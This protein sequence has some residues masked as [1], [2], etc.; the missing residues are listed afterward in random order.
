MVTLAII[1]TVQEPT[2]WCSAMV[3]V[4]KS[5]ESCRICVDSRELNKQVER[6]RHPLP[7]TDHALGQLG[8]VKF[9]KIDA[10]SGFWPSL[11]LLKSPIF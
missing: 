11:S 8:N 5:N 6:E 10:Y 3:V 9:S 2:E 7:V 4:T 1:E